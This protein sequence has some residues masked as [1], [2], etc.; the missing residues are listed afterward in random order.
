M[1][2][3]DAS[4]RFR[5]GT[6]GN[7]RGRQPGNGTRQR[8]EAAVGGRLDRIIERLIEMALE[9]DVQAARTLLERVAP[10]LRA[11][12]EPVTLT[13]GAEPADDART[14]L[15]ALG[16]GSVTPSE[17]ATIMRSIGEAAKVRELADLEARIE[18]IEQR[19]Q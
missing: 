12:D 5:P 7:P 2:E 16:A 3:R 19:Q 1:T 17:A 9:G 6:S 8:I 11:R 18:A 4:G 13:L 15:G 10:P 14:V